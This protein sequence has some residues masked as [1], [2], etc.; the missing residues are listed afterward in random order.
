MNEILKM[1]K[2]TIKVIAV[3]LF[4]FFEKLIWEKLAVP[5]RNWFSTLKVS[6]KFG[7]WLGERST[8]TKFWFF[9]LPFIVAEAMGIISG[10]MIVGGY[11]LIGLGIYILKI[12]VAGLTFW[13]FGLVKEDLLKLDWFETLYLLVIRFL[14]F[15]KSTEIY[16][17]VIVRIRWVKIRMKRFSK[18]GNGFMNEM[19]NTY[20][21]IAAI[22]KEDK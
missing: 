21:H 15:I 19:E 11:V 12:P 16:Q 20:A 4:L 3:I 22:F 14:N 18:D 6:V 2:N 9:I 13:I 8:F 1:L 7:A 10:S 5:F 17:S